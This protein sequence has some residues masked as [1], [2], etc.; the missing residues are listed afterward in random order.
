MSAIGALIR[1]MGSGPVFVHSDPFRAARLV[2][3]VRDRNAYLDSHIAVLCDAAASQPLWLPTFNYDFP[4][5][6]VFDVRASESQLGPL[7]E[8]FR[9]DRAEWRTP[10]PIFSI[11]GIGRASQPRWGFMTD[12]FGEDSVFADL[13]RSD[14]VVLYYGDTFNYNTLV[15]FSER[16]AGGPVYRYDKIFPGRVIIADGTSVDG[17][18]DYHVRP[19]GTGL[20]YDWL[21][22]LDEALSAGVCRRLESAPEILAASASQLNELWVDGMKRDPFA[23]LD[24]KTRQWAEPRVNELGRRFSISD[25]ETAEGQR[26]DG[27]AELQRNA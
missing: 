11:A 3:P 5:I 4:R 14:G 2:K 15:H 6:G 24:D 16:V 21:R 26:A 7:P 19:M 18:L 8:R 1:S 20:E 12:P 9:T 22:L 10:I 17:S 13:V 25:F 27:H 23:L